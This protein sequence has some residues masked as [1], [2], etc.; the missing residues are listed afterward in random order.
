[1]DYFVYET[2]QEAADAEALIFQRGTAIAAEVGHVIDN[3]VVGKTGSIDRPD[4][5]RTGAWCPP[6]QRLD[7]KWV[8]AHPQHHPRADDVVD[9]DGRTYAAIVT[10]GLAAPV[11][12]ESADW[13]PEEE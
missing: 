1:M 3:G 2:E 7:G 9:A 8:V 5:A 10:E 6:R 4:A 11:E 12:T 13:W